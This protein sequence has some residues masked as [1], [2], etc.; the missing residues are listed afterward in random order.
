[1]YLTT[2]LLF[3]FS[4]ALEEEQAISAAAS[5]IASSS[6]PDSTRPRVLEE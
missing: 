6:V 4:A 5:P 3:D 2:I 1:L